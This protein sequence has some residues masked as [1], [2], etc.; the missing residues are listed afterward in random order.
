MIST[1]DQTVIIHIPVEKVKIRFGGAEKEVLN[2]AQG[3]CTAEY[4]D[5]NNFPISNPFEEW[6][7]STIINSGPN[8]GS[9]D[10]GQRLYIQLDAAG[11]ASSE[12]QGISTSTN[13]VTYIISGI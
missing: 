1:D 6:I 13:D 5:G 11:P 7:L 12:G 4:A 9:G 10:K 3:F 8:P 2:L